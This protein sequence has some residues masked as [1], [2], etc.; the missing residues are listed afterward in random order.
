[1]KIIQILSDMALGGPTY[2]VPSSCKALMSLGNHV[3]LYV[4]DHNLVSCED[5]ETKVFTI[6]KNPILSKIGY[7]K[8]LRKQLEK[9]CVDA[10]I[11]QTNSMWL[12]SNIIPEL[13]RKKSRAKS[14]IMPRGTLTD[15]ALSISRWKK[16]ISLLLGQQY[17]LNKADLFIATCVD[18][19]EDIR[20]FGLKAPVAIIPNGIDVPI[21]DEDSLLKKEANRVVFLSRI[22][23]KK[24]VDILIHAWSKVEKKFPQWKLSIVGPIDEY[25]IKM[26]RLAQ[27]LGCNNI[28]F[29]GTINGPQK[30]EYL[31]RSSFFILPTHSENFGI[32]VAEALACG[33]PAICT[34]G[35]PWK[36]LETHKCGKWIELNEDNVY[37]ALCEFINK[38]SEELDAMGK[39]GRL[40]VEKEFSWASIGAKMQK[41]YEWIISPNT[42]EKPTFIIEE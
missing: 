24:G 34:K 3:V 14:V 33:I 42:I 21:I 37:S 8:D 35:A 4:N 5:V 22:H 29:P 15:Y 2:T 13:S 39:R 16:N 18:E 41:A 32:A 9:E 1:M 25:A 27:D 28:D 31:S 36:G 20:R 19:Y 10:D 6:S 30:N 23:K 38:N 26:Q 40:W 11:I 12:Y 7:S 17:A